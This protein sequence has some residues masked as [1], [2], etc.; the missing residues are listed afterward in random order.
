MGKKH[1]NSKFQKEQIRAWKFYDAWRKRGSKCPAFGGEMIYVT[2]IGWDHLVDPSKHRTVQEKIRRFEALP[3]AKK[4]IEIS[5]TYQEY[6][7]DHG[8]SFWAFQANLDGKKIKVIVS[9]KN[10]KKCFLSVIVFK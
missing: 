6:R 10:K 9:A 3:L 1:K 7:E 5:T 4:L 2:R 8:I